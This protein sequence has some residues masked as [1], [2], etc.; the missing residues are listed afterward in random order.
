MENWC[1]R[2]IVLSVR[3]H[4]E[5]G[6]VVSLLTE[7]YGRHAGYVR[8]IASS[9]L[10]GVAE[11]GN[12][13]SAAWSSR[14]S[15]HLGAFV[16]EPE[17]ALVAPLMQDPL[18]LAALISACSLCDVSLPEREAHPG[19]FHGLLALIEALDGEVWGP[20]YILWEIA[21]MRELGFGLELNKCAAGGDTAT[22]A[23]V[24]PK[25]G[26]A[27]S[28]EKAEPYKDKL[29]PLP[30]F[31]KPGGSKIDDAET[32]RGLEMIGHFLEHWVFAQH[33]K[34]VPE[35]RLRFQERLKKT[36]ENGGNPMVFSGQ[37]A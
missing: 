10:R 6:A 20:A 36:L 7:N 28:A 31:L 21:F 4:G 3:P 34:G 14:L 24:S 26:R 30:D 23:Y 8:G 12:L 16:I 18:R 5:S 37:T 17:R 29:L 35:P 2:G 13:V 1:D 25:S 33:T 11:P 15:D 27:V 19:L 9:K 22:L 32:L